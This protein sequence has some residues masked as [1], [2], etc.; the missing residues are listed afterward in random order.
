MKLRGMQRAA[1]ASAGADLLPKASFHF[2]I[3]H[4][5]GTP[6]KMAI[7]ADP[8]AWLVGGPQTY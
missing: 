6:D 1:V 3:R 7:V 5:K 2:V 8:W 4:G